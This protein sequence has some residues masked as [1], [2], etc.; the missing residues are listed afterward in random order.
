[1]GHLGE[2]IAPC[3]PHSGCCSLHPKPPFLWVGTRNFCQILNQIALPFSLGHLMAA[4][5]HVGS[6]CHLSPSNGCSDSSSQRCQV[7]SYLFSL[8]WKELKDDEIV[9]ISPRLPQAADFRRGS[10][11]R[12]V[13]RAEGNTSVAMPFCRRGRGSKGV[14]LPLPVW[15]FDC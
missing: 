8:V 10:T 4:G 5:S 2:F 13:R 11:I 14:N 1:M 9:P 12:E 15:A 6:A 3:C 7:Y